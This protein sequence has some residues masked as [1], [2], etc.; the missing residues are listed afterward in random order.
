[1]WWPSPRMTIGSDI[2]SALFNRF[3][4]GR[5][6][7]VKDV[8]AGFREGFV[9]EIDNVLQWEFATNDRS[10]QFEAITFRKNE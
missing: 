3:G 9:F 4:D 8:I 1:M 2:L 6:P 5:D 10:D 7:T